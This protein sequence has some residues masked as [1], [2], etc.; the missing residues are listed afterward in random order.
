MDSPNAN[1]LHQL[2]AE[3]LKRWPIERLREMTLEEYTNLRSNTDDYFCHWVE[4]KTESLGSIQGATSAKFG[5]YHAN[6]LKN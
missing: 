6:N 4:R 2:W 3:F 1:D 5:I